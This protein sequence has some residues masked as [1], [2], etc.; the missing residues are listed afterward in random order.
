ML[1]RITR[2]VFAGLGRAYSGLALF[3]LIH[4]LILLGIGGYA[5]QTGRIDRAKIER[6]SV[7]IRGDEPDEPEVVAGG[8]DVTP[9]VDG[10]AESS[11]DL[12]EQAM[13]RDEMERLQRERA[14][15]D[16]RN[17]S[18]LVD[19][20]MVKLQRDQEAHDQRVARQNEQMN[21]R[22]ESEENAARQETINTIGG[23]D[24]KKARDFLMNLAEADAV[25]ILLTLPARKR[26]G[27][28]EACKTPDQTRWR[29][30]VLG[31]MLTQPAGAREN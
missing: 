1:K 28:L 30:K 26:K 14:L 18:L 16:I 5:Y 15:A 2:R 4:L 29:D 17:E 13:K 24:S 23:L 22:R 21:K 19:R 27:I 12:I 8:S 7:I 20:R 3:A 31:A 10:Q 6:I 25:K 11:E 9:E